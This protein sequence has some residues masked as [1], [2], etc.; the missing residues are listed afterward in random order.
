LPTSA[1]S[2]L[3]GVP[4]TVADPFI[5]SLETR[6]AEYCVAAVAPS[7]EGRAPPQPTLG[8]V[9]VGVLGKGRGSSPRHQE[10]VPASIWRNWSSGRPQFL[11]A[12]Q[13]PP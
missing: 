8:Y 7:G 13:P 1:T 12:L 5:L 11:A 2:R 3:Y 9:V 10:D 6:L 4:R